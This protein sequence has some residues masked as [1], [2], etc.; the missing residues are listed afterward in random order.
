[1]VETPRQQVVH[2]TDQPAHQMHIT[3]WNLKKQMNIL[4]MM[5]QHQSL[6]EQYILASLIRKLDT[7]LA[8]VM[9]C[10]VKFQAKVLRQKNQA[11]KKW[12]N[13]AHIVDKQWVV[14]TLLC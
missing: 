7:L 3:V 9:I 11:K 14:E 10:Q 12:T 4:S 1:M 6:V 2:I 5:C 13:A 8:V